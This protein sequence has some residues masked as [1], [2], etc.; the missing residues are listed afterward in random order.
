MNLF[1][2][3]SLNS[4]CLCVAVLVT[5]AVEY[6][7]RT[8]LSVRPDPELES[9]NLHGKHQICTVCRKLLQLFSRVDGAPVDLTVELCANV[10]YEPVVP[11]GAPL[12]IDAHPPFVSFHQVDVT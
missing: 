12:G 4:K 6:N 2:D 5:F 1:V 8:A 3:C 9:L 11:E 7:V 10:L